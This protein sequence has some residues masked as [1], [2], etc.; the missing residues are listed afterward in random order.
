M[1]IIFKVSAMAAFDD[2]L[3]LFDSL[4]DALRWTRWGRGRGT[5]GQEGASGQC[6]GAG[7]PVALTLLGYYSR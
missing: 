3:G 6:Y 2:V 4:L 7:G 5:G 1:V